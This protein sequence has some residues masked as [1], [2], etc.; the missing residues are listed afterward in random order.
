MARGIHANM[1]NA[2]EAG[3]VKPFFLID[4]EF[5]SPV[6]LWSGAY[7]L[8]HNNNSYVGTG[9]LLTVEVPE[10]TQDIGAVGVKLTMSG[11]G[12]SILTPALQQEYQGKAVTVKLGAFDSNMAIIA[13]PVIVFE[14]FMDTMNIVEG[15]ETSTITLYVEN[16]LIRLDSANERRYTLQDQLIDHA[17]DLGFEFVTDIQEKQIKWG[18]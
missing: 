9:E 3:A 5:A 4:L 1:V 10:E 16:K 8:S 11:L 2:L 13:N 17:G 7:T 18:T 12:S 15:A 6:Y 14:G